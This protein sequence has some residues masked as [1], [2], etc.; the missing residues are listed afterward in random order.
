MIDFGCEICYDWNRRIN[1]TKQWW[2]N[3]EKDW[4]D[5][6]GKDLPCF[7]AILSVL[8]ELTLEIFKEKLP[9]S[10][11]HSKM[12]NDVFGSP[13][14]FNN[15][16]QFTSL[17]KVQKENWEPLCW[18]IRIFRNGAAHLKDVHTMNPHINN[19]GNHEDSLQDYYRY[20]PYPDLRKKGQEKYD[21][22]ELQKIHKLIRYT[23]LDKVRSGH[24]NIPT[25]Q[26]FYE[27]NHIERGPFIN[28]LHVQLDELLKEI[29][30]VAIPPLD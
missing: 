16:C 3:S 24:S 10:N 7:I 9:T 18:S 5:L 2:K 26:I 8:R 6:N 30:A 22:S 4:R 21:E 29:K 12:K 23:I 19:P 13:L 27:L 1:I 20:A 14:V 25:G 17:S 28:L 11:N 15:K